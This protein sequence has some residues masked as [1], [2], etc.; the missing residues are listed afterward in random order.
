MI[1]YRGN[2]CLAAARANLTADF[3]RKTQE[4]KAHHSFHP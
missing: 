1:F 3:T 4:E 2:L